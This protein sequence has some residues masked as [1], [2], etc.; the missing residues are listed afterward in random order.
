MALSF[1]QEAAEYA[2]PEAAVLLEELAVSLASVE[3]DLALKQESLDQSLLVVRERTQAMTPEQRR[4]EYIAWDQANAVL[5]DEVDQ[6]RL[7]KANLQSQAPARS[8]SQNAPLSGAS[9]G[10]TGWMT[11][12]HSAEASLLALREATRELTPE[13]RR[14]QFIAWEKQQASVA[15]LQSVPV[16]GTTAL[17]ESP[18][19]GTAASSAAPT[20]PV[21]TDAVLS[22]VATLSE[23]DAL[24]VLRD[25]ARS[26]SPEERRALYLA[27]EQSN[28]NPGEPS[29]TQE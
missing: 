27:F 23:E 2:A 28:Q 21:D 10:E 13:E 18:T 9:A 20:A 3:A 26:M 14:A 5:I 19:L 25:A 8:F 4:A 7:Q 29:I 15:P 12:G 17:F 16:S 22:A 24:V 1:A 11:T 6:L